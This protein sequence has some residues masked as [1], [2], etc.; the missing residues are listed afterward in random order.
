MIPVDAV[1]VRDSEPVAA[2]VKEEVV[3]LSLRAGAYF[4]LNP[5]GS[6]IWNLLSQPRRFGELCTML[7][8]I[9]DVDTDTVLRET[10]GF[11]E[12]LLAR[13]LVRMVDPDSEQ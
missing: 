5:V 4:G 1:F 12:A 7:S 2:T 8:R 13:G 6:E 9:Y 10:G 3:M 11:L